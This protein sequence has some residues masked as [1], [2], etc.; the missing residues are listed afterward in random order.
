MDSTANRSRSQSQSRSTQDLSKSKE[1]LS[2]S[3]EAITKSMEAL[4]HHAEEACK[5]P[6]ALTEKN[7]ETDKLI[8][9]EVAQTGRVGFFKIVLNFFSK[10]Y[11]PHI[12]LVP[13]PYD[14]YVT[15]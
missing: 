1:A 11:Y 15:V 4:G 5:P 8:Q 7:K 2:K 9:E 6:K 12:I 14:K 3:R 10:L 13:L